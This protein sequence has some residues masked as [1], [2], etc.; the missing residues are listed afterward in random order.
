MKKSKSGD[1][2]AVFAPEFRLLQ[3]ILEAASDTVTLRCS[4]RSAGIALRHRIYKARAAD[5]A[6]NPT[7][8]S[9]FD[10]IR[11]SAPTLDAERGWIMK[12][13]KLNE[14]DLLKM[15]E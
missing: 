4:S 14:E 12:I 15:L 6:T 5:R 9:I 11:I 2:Y 13:T 7:G 1:P 10:P 8:S 3:G